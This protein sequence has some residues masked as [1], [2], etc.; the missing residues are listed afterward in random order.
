MGTPCMHLQA[1]APFKHTRDILHIHMLSQVLPL[2]P[3]TYSHVLFFGGGVS[4]RRTGL[5][6]LALSLALR[7]ASA[8]PPAPFPSI[9]IAACGEAAIHDAS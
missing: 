1:C 6:Y 7:A 2:K 5:A 4:L 3:K 8:L 9:K